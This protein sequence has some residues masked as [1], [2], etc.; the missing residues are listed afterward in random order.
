MNIVFIIVNKIKFQIIIIINKMLTIP[1]DGIVSHTYPDSSTYLGNC[2][3]GEPNGY[4]EY[5]KLDGDSYMG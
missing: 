1:N 2:T 5:T 3:N 4:G